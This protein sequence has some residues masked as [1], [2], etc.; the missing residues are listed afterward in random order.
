[1]DLTLIDLIIHL[2]NSLYWQSISSLYLVILF[3]DIVYIHLF[4][5]AV[6]YSF[7]RNTQYVHI[8]FVITACIHKMLAVS[9]T[10]PTQQTLR[11]LIRCCSVCF[12]IG[13]FH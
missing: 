2:L 5:T 11:P 9:K 6:T 12:P 8:L 13:P 4:L 10:R 7:I 1:M 3:F